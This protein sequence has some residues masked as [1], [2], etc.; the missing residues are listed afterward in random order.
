MENSCCDFLHAKIKV[1]LKLKFNSGLWFKYEFVNFFSGLWFNYV[2][3]L[4]VDYGLNMNLYIY[5][6]DY[7]LTMYI[8]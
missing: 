4:I 2:H 5:L 7:G 3:N 1:F 8:I 6:V